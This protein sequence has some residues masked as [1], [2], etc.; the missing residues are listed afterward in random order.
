MIQQNRVAIKSAVACLLLLSWAL[1]A[2]VHA[3]GLSKEIN[4]E[5]NVDFGGT[6]VLDSDLGSIQ[7][8]S[9][10][11]K[12]VK[13]TVYL[14]SDTYNERKAE[15]LFEDFHLSFEQN[16][17]DVIIRGE[18]DGGWFGG[19]RKRLNVHF[20]I[21][22]PEE[23]NLNLETAGGSIDVE[24]I[25]GEVKL[26][27]SGGSI[28]MGKISGEVRAKTSG[29]SISLEGASGSADVKT[30]GGRISLGE[31]DGNVV[32]KTSGGSI[33]VD[34]ANGDLVA[35]TSGGPIHLR[36]VN[37]NLEASTSGGSITAELLKQVDRSVVLRTSGGSIKLDVPSNFQAD[38]DASTSGG[39]V[40]TDLPVTVRGSISKSELHGQLNGGGP[41]LRLHTSGGSII[42]K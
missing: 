36:R 29:G 20:D 24:D 13:V 31:I 23:Y 6:L 26:Y 22:V 28:D 7:V 39:R 38:I 33:D 34:G 12:Q 25:R 1:I 15:A 21:V 3:S 42:I 5:F 41:E 18:R 11:S 30:S 2:N 27:T 14:R 9:H 17:R 10:A 4:K 19:W 40:S 16:G 35:H 8:R 37:G 32:A